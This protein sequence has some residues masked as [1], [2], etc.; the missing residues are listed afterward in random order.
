MG[1]TAPHKNT[2]IGYPVIS[3]GGGIRLSLITNTGMRFLYFYA[4]EYFEKNCPGR[5]GRIAI[6]QISKL[7]QSNFK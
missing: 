7:F 5:P 4:P 3:D 2:E 1:M 6:N